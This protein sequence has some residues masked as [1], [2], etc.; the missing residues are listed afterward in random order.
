MN[1]DTGRTMMN[2][3]SAPIVAQ[4]A[5]VSAQA[6]A[7]RES[8][9]MQ[10]A[11]LLARTYPRDEDLAEKKLIKA[12]GRLA[13]AEEA[14]Y[15]YVK[16]GSKISGPSIR[17]A[18][19][20]GRC[21]GSIFCG[22]EETRG[23]NSSEWR[24]YAWDLE[25]LWGDEKLFTVKHWVDTKEGGRPARDEREIYEIG[26]NQA[27]RRKR[28]DILACIPQYIQDGAVAE[29]KRT[30]AAK[31]DT[32]PERVAAM[33]EA[34]KDYSVT[35][36]MIEKKIQSKLEAITPNGMV[37]LRNIYNSLRDGVAKVADFFEIAAAAPS[38]G[39]DA[40]ASKSQTDRVKETLRGRQASTESGGGKRKPTSPQR[41]E[42]KAA[43]PAEPEGG[44]GAIP[45][46]DQPGAITALREAAGAG[47]QAIVDCLIRIVA[48]FVGTERAFPN[49][50]AIE[51]LKPCKDSYALT[52]VMSTLNESYRNADLALPVEVEAFYN[53]RLEVIDERKE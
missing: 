24:T 29:V 2:P 50:I 34:F 31:T 10:S 4:P 38:S 3:A 14:L 19:E 6:L 7:V 52:L 49:S 20:M 42:S 47:A 13:L 44:Q 48:D 39:V 45:F 15:E 35:A 8:T 53:E 16:G 30:L 25:T 21:W 40:E 9:R 51:A 37:T 1:T 17:L 12:C 32:S 43:A 5:S 46:Y 23:T 11:M 18:E 36:E 41:A 22:V 27:A 33:L 28:A 26:A